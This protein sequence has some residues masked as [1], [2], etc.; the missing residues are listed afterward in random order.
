VRE[1]TVDDAEAVARIHVRAWQAAY[2]GILPDDLLAELDPVERAVLRRAHLADPDR[3]TTNVVAVRDAAIVGFADAGPYDLY[4][5]PERQNPDVGEVYA[6]YVD[7]RHWGT[8]AGRALMRA[9]LADL[10]AQ[11]PRP[12]RLWV[13]TANDRA[14]RFYE[15]CGFIADG[16]ADTFTAH[17][18]DGTVVDLD[19]IRYAQHGRRRQ[20]GQA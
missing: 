3:V 13:L 16:A 6:I 19:E 18:P 11:G 14:R 17:R 9:A 8:G 20:D 5:N 7:P 1:A 2:A 10:T 4:R 12:V 15:R